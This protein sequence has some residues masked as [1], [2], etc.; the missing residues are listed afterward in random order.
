MEGFLMN[1]LYAEIA[2]RRGARTSPAYLQETTIVI[3]SILI[4]FRLLWFRLCI[5]YL[6]RWIRNKHNV[7]EVILKLYWVSSYFF[8]Q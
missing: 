7:S 4:V 6:Y 8:T 2:P 1:G 5:S 3:D